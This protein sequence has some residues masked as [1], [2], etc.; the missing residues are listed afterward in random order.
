MAFWQKK[1][2]SAPESPS[3]DNA[4][5]PV[6]NSPAIGT[7]PVKLGFRIGGLET[8]VSSSEASGTM[9]CQ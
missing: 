1:P 6:V 8:C 4:A 2:A 3:L 5:Q 7:R 9:T